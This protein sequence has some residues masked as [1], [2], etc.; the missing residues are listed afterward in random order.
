MRSLNPLRH[1]L[2]STSPIDGR[3]LWAA[4]RTVTAS[5]KVRQQQARRL[6][7]LLEREHRV[8]GVALCGSGT[9]ALLLALETG[10][11]L[12][13]A[14]ATVILPAFSCFD[15]AAA[16]ARF[17]RAVRFYDV[18]P[19]T[20]GPEP[21]SLERALRSV[22]PN[23]SIVV[24]ASLFGIPLDWKVLD[25]L[26]EASGALVIEDAAQGHG[27]RWDG[28][29]LGGHGR[30]GVLSFSRGK[31]WTGGAGGA[32]LVRDAGDVPRAGLGDAAAPLAIDLAG[33]HE[34]D[35]KMSDRELSRRRDIANLSRATAHWILGRPGLYGLPRRLPWLGLGETRLREVGAPTKMPPSAVALALESWSRA[36]AA[37]P[38]RQ[39][40]AESYDEGLRGA[41]SPER[42]RSP[43]GG[44]GGFIRFPIL[45]PSG[46][47]SFD[48]PRLARTLGAEAS[49]PTPLPALPL[50]KGLHA[51][52]NATQALRW[53]GAEAL[54]KVLVTLPTHPQ[55]R[56]AERERLM[57][58]LLESAPD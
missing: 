4:A 20:L 21:D 14:T 36:E 6:E 34:R 19:R 9:E 38:L 8:A 50:M 39:G 48:D 7:E 32:L 16:A 49:Y 10:E 43:E 5:R 40:I 23:A 18:S 15:V 54:S 55:T 25:P 26:L 37:V 13:D 30:L 42:V 1:Q 58:Q 46:M 28:T 12:L 17:G 35:R 45:L 56:Q 52:G 22:T 44:V 33:A 57:E 53:P 24:L 2:P 29:R 51:S 3:G 47:D 31:G 27:A 11:R 41:G